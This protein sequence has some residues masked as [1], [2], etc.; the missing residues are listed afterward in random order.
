MAWHNAPMLQ[1]KVDMKPEPQ[2][3]S[4]AEL[5]P[6]E[7]AA[8]EPAPKVRAFTLM[9][10]E[11]ASDA[12]VIRPETTG[13]TVLELFRSNTALPLLAVADETGIV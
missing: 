12:P 13:A 9:A 4:E 6:A 5:R 10:R 7:I 11:L 1:T 3:R 2:E 8:I